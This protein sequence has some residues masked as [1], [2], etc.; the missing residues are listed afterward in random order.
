VRIAFIIASLIT[1]AAVLAVDVD[2]SGYR[3]GAGVAVAR[4]GM[5]LTCRWPV[6]DTGNE[7]ASMTFQLA[8]DRPLI[9]E[10]TIGG[11]P[12]LVDV[13]PVLVMTVGSRNLSDKAGWIAFF[14]NPPTRPHAAHLAELRR[15]SARVETDGAG[16]R[17]T[18]IIGGLTCGSFRGDMRF[19]FFPGSPL[20]QATAVVSTDEDS[21]A[22]L[23]DAGL[24]AHKPSWKNVA[25]IDNVTD[26]L[27]EA[28][29]QIDAATPLAVRHRTIVAQSAARTG[30]AVAVFP[31]PHRYLYPL[32]FA[33]NF[34]F[35]WQ[36]TNW[37]DL[38]KQT[39]FGVRQTIEGDKRY[40]PW[41]NA[42]PKTQQRLS[43]F[44]LLSRGDAAQALEQVKRYTHGDT[45]K[46]LDGHKIFTSHYHIEH[47]LDFVRRQREQGTNSVPDGLREPGFV[48]AFKARGV[49]IVHLAEFHVQHTPEMNAKRID[50]LR[51]LHDECDRLSE[52]GKFLLLP[53]EEPN[54]HLGGHWIS[55]FPKPVYWTLQRGKDQP[56]VEQ[57]DGVGNIYHVGSAA[58][59][60]K[61][62][63]AEH[64]LMWTAHPRIKGSFGFPD[65]Y[66]NTD[67]FKSD[68]FLGGAWKSMP[69][70]YSLPRL[71]TRV[72]DLL[73]D[74]N[75]WGEPKMAVGEVDVFKVEPEYELYG[76]MNVNYLK[77]EHVPRFAKGWQPVLDALRAG[78]FFVT[79][80][81]IVIPEWSVDRK[82]SVLT[83]KLEWTFPLAFA[84]IITGDGAQIQRRRIDLSDSQSFGSRT[85]TVPALD[86]RGKKW[87]RLEVWDVAT[88]G[89]F[90]QP[91]RVDAADSH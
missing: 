76:H 70:D 53:G 52:E 21:R 35:V 45:F 63:E 27:R 86:L 57:V 9:T 61:L 15:T 12:I 80:G 81:E 67:F 72:L 13:D 31:P 2:L 37:R 42:P 46:P 68:R 85:L 82:S 30:G 77:L 7:G 28:S 66:R 38:V 59:V 71:G 41:V 54:V 36:G 90:T 69:A 40:V 73:D 25:W 47:T 83:A 50:L 17:T 64:G 29:P 22:I 33:E 87:V 62:M 26:K 16:G 55:F 88:N 24:A 65:A 49:D 19:T 56:F 1:T 18:L 11:T 32:D 74:M 58:D 10:L 43:V 78:N 34:Q 75:N 51:A 5:R 91:I 60:L 79:T 39:G 4:D 89:A 44:Y 6:D 48:K 3:E 23:F 8:P 20:V 14:D 84:E